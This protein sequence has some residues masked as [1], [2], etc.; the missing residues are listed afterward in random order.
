MP[1]TLL[2]GTVAE[3]A[4]AV[5]FLS[6]PGA[7]DGQCSRLYCY[8]TEMTERYAECKLIS[9]L[10]VH[11]GLHES[12]PSPVD[13]ESLI[14]L[15]RVDSE[16]APHVAV[17]A[18][19]LVR[20]RLAN[21]GPVFDGSYMD[22][23]RDHQWPPNALRVPVGPGI[24]GRPAPSRTQQRPSTAPNSASPSLE[25][26]RAGGRAANW[27]SRARGS[28]SSGPDAMIFWFVCRNL[29]STLAAVDTE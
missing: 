1:A 25:I 21:A 5:T 11:R 15:G 19:Q 12:E 13:G 4:A 18:A 8:S 7:F 6:G 26:T 29:G 2:V 17:M 10:A 28:S 22:Q 23:Y 24:T 27:H 3:L 20:R 14:R 9:E 16:E